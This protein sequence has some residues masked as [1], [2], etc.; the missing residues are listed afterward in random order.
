MMFWRETEN[1]IYVNSYLSFQ[2]FRRIQSI[3]IVNKDAMIGNEEICKRMIDFFEN[4]NFYEIVI[5]GFSFSDE[6]EKR[7]YEIINSMPMLLRV[8][9]SERKTEVFKDIW[10]SIV[11]S[12][13]QFSH[14]PR[15][16]RQTYNNIAL[17]LLT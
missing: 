2:D 12:F 6:L 8:R 16:S 1:V 4:K 9:Y 11:Y 7:F 3:S 13:F 5:E 10:K 17:N 14:V 15:R